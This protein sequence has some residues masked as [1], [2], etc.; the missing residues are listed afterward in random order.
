MILRTF[1][2]SGGASGLS[3]YYELIQTTN[4]TNN[5][6]KIIQKNGIKGANGQNGRV[7]KSTGLEVR[8]TGTYLGFDED[9]YLLCKEESRTTEPIADPECLDKYVT[10]TETSPNPPRELYMASSIVE[11]KRFLLEQMKNPTLFKIAQNTYNNIES[12]SKINRSIASNSCQAN[13]CSNK[14]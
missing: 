10:S 8:V 6:P 14:V 2:F 9:G 5:V 3:G 11:Y 13:T 12:N 4:S 1:Q 7:C